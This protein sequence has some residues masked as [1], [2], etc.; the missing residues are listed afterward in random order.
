MR[1]IKV[2]SGASKYALRGEDGVYIGELL[3]DYDP[4]GKACRVDISE[5]GEEM[6]VSIHSGRG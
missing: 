6:T 2:K 3:I 1:G 4:S 5:R